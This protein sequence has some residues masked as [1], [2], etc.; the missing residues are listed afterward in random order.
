MIGSAIGSHIGPTVK[1]LR[2]IIRQLDVAPLQNLYTLLWNGIKKLVNRNIYFADFLEMFG[3]ESSVR[4]H[5]LE[6][7]TNFLISIRDDRGNL[8]IEV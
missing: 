8:E 6:I 3:Q 4:L 7:I 1:M 5:I 2:R